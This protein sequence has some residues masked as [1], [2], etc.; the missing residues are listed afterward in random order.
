MVKNATLR[1]LSRWM[2]IACSGFLMQ[3][4]TANSQE[5]RLRGSTSDSLNERV[6]AQAALVEAQASRAKSFSEAKKSYAEASSMM[7][8]AASQGIDLEHK[9]I[10]SYWK[11]KGSLSAAK[12]DNLEKQIED[13]RQP[14]VREKAAKVIVWDR[15][16]EGD[17]RRARPAIRSGKLLNRVAHQIDEVS[18]LSSSTSVSRTVTAGLAKLDDQSLRQLNVVFSS[19]NGPV[20]VSLVSPL[21]DLMTQWPYLFLDDSLR[22]HS[23]KVNQV[24]K[25][26]F[27]PNATKFEKYDTEKEVQR[28]I[29]D[30]ANAF[31][32]KYPISDRKS[33]SGREIRR[34]YTAERFLEQLDRTL[35][36]LM[37][38]DMSGVVRRPCYVDEY[39]PEDRNA[40]TLIQYMMTYGIEFGPAR[41]GSELVYDRL[42]LQYRDLARTLNAAPTVDT[43]TEPII[44]LDLD[45]MVADE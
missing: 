28:V 13:R 1:G 43:I 19:L 26:L 41:T 11:K 44:N 31:Y 23:Y 12:W 40:A 22:P 36:A 35:V 20:D 42:F 24:A 2:L 16:I 45:A 32:R 4:T 38:T 33:L 18:S 27:D 9:Q 34:I 8:E 10:L 5:L 39:D 29:A 7:V 3:G 17:L 15:T 21:P 30:A 6:K 14:M 25:R 37:E